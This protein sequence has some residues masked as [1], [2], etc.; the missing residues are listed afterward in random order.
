[1]SRAI[2][3]ARGSSEQAPDH[4]AH[5]ELDAQDATIACVARDGGL[6]L[7]RT[8]TDASTHDDRPLER[9]SGLLNAIGVLARG[10]TLVVATRERLGP[11]P[12]QIAKIRA[13][14]GLEGMP[15]SRGRG[16]RHTVRC[17]SPRRRHDSQ[18]D[19]HTRRVRAVRHGVSNADDLARTARRHPA[20]HG[21]TRRPVT[22]SGPGRS[23]IDHSGPPAGWLA[24]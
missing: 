10:D 17:R 19:R 6:E 20:G 13:T 3:Y 16:F 7:V 22:R 9:R 15:T 24:A 18:H 12:V 2:G 4:E 23:P 5:D 14:R 8:Y 21:T 11:S 1:M